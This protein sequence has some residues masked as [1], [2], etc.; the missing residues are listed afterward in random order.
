M[1]RLTMICNGSPGGV[2]I[3]KRRG[4]FVLPKFPKG[5]DADFHAKA[6]GD[7]HARFLIS[8]IFVQKPRLDLR[9]LVRRQGV[10]G[11]RERERFVNPS[12]QALWPAQLWFRK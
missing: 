3:V 10:Q 9:P 2:G 7:P 6:A 12:R 5:L 4:A 8:Q 11:F 1:P